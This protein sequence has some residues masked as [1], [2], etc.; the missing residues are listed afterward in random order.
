MTGDIR[1]SMLS[2]CDFEAEARNIAEFTNYLERNGLGRVATAPF[3]FRDLSTRRWGLLAAHCST[4]HLP[5]W[6]SA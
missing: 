6:P 2:E 5:S 3:V 4:A 1:Q